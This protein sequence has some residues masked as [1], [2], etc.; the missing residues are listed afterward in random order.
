MRVLVTG[1]EGY[2]GT[3]LVRLLLQT[4]HEVV[5]LDTGWY[6]GCEFGAAPPVVPTIRRDVRDAEPGD[7][8]GFDAVIHLAALSNDPLGDLNPECTHAINHRAAARVAVLAKAAGVPRF[9]FASSCALYG[10]AGEAPLAE[11]AQF[12]PLTPYGDSKVQAERD[13]SALADGCFSPTFFRSAT[14]Y[15]IS[16]MLRADLVVNN[17]VGYACTT[18]EVRIGS[19]GTPWRP[20]VHVEDIA[21]AYVAGLDAPRERIHD[22]AFNVGVSSENYQIREVAAIVAEVVP[23]ARVTY[24]D[25][26]GPDP[27]CYRV[28]CEKIAQALPDFRPKWN[29]RQGIEQLYEGYLQVGLTREEFLGSRYLRIRRITQLLDEHRLDAELHWL[30]PAAAPRIGKTHRDALSPARSRP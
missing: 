6:A 12:N 29:L 18:G 1:H 16:P 20:L 26:G 10:R 3:V 5:G 23:G 11:D 9:L 13:I 30:R 2:I 8:E 27:R 19:D 21:A 25:G 15:G 7:L 28:S 14:A 17:L 4:G 24:A 22:Q